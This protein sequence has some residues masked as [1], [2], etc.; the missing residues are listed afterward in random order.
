MIVTGDL[1]DG[2]CREIGAS[3]RGASPVQ[4]LQQ[5]VSRGADTEKF[6]A[7][8]AKRSLSNADLGTESG[9]IEFLIDM[10]RQGVLEARHD[11]G[12]MPSRP[13]Y[14]VR[15]VVIGQALDHGEHFPF[16]RSRDV[17]AL[18][19]PIS[20]FCNVTGLPEQTL[21]SQRFGAREVVQRSCVRRDDCPSVQCVA[22]FGELL[23]R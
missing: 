19:Q 11:G 18:D 1:R 23:G 7:T 17:L 10:F 16:Q 20:C 14:D 6:G 8:H 22:A 2:C 5:D 3:Q 21:E 9:D 13:G 12:V 15:L 4:A